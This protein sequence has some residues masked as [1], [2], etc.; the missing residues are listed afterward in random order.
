MGV[1]WLGS[2][3]GDRFKRYLEGK[4]NRSWLLIENIKKGP[5]YYFS[6]V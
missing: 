1:D 5:N 4:I 3:G 6:F 2:D